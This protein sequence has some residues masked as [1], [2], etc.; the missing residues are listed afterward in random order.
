M[1]KYLGKSFVV[2]MMSWE[3]KIYRI[4]E[5]WFRGIDDGMFSPT[6]S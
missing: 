5:S 3:K 4:N 2:R 6:V 1:M